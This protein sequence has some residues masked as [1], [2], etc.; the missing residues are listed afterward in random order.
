MGTIRSE[1]SKKEQSER[2]KAD[3]ASGKRI[4]HMTGKKFS[5]ESRL[6]MSNSHKGKPA[7]SKGKKA[8]KRSGELHWNW[9]GGKSSEKHK[10]R[11]S[12]EWKIWRLSVFER[13]SY[14]CQECGTNSGYLE[15]HH[16]IPIRDNK[17]Q[18]F[19]TNNGITLCRPCHQKTIW[20]ESDYQ[21]KYSKIVA[22]QM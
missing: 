9:K 10:L 18:L 13:D 11:N 14:T 8:P 22:A 17:E 2:M 4:H 1:K 16:I 6:K 21:E 19:D 15:P 3:Y 12:L 7:P 5:E 20:V